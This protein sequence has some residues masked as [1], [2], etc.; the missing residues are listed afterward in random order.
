[1]YLLHKIYLLRFIVFTSAICIGIFC[2]SSLFAQSSVRFSLAVDYDFECFN[3]LDDDQDGFVDDADTDCENPTDNQE[4]PLTNNVPGTS[5]GNFL[6]PVHNALDV[7]LNAAPPEEDA[8]PTPTVCTEIPPKPYRLCV[9]KNRI[10]AYDYA[11][12]VACE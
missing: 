12:D 3:G 10:S 4:S 7:I 1:M 11:Q 6:P 5:G 2:F 8:P 9:P